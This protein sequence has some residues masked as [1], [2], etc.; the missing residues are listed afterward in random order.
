VDQL[1]QAKLKRHGGDAHAGLAAVATAE[2]RSV[3][4]SVADADVRQSLADLPTP[5]RPPLPSTVPYEPDARQRYTLTRLHATGGIGQVW[6]AHDEDLGRDVALKELRPDRRDNPAAAARFLEEAKITGQLEHPGIVPVYELVLPWEGQ[7]CYAMRFVGGRTLADAIREYHRKRQA[8]EAGPLDLRELLTAFVAV[9]NAVA[10]AHSRGVLHRDLKPANVALGDFG[11]VLL[12]DWGL[13]KVVGKAEEPTSL[14]PVAVGP[15]DG[16]GETRQGQVLGTPAYMPPEQARGR[17]DLVDRR[18]DVYGLGAI[19]YEV[20]T[21]EPPF[22]GADAQEVLKRVVQEP[23]LPPRRTVPTTP[24]ALQAVC[25]KAMAKEP[26]ARYET[27]RDLGRDVQHWLA[28]EPVAA[29]REPLRARAGRW[30]RRH[31]QLT[32]GLVVL[33]LTGLV[34]LGVGL[35]AVRAEQVRTAHERDL[36]EANL[37]LAKQAV[38][39]CFQLAKEHPLLQRD[40]MREVR[41]LLLEK[42]LPFYERFRAQRPDDPEIRAETA[43]NHYRVG[44]I[45]AELGR[46]ADAQQVYGQALRLLE[47]LAQE[48]PDVTQ[49]QDHLAW[50]YTNLGILQEQSGRRAEAERSYEEARRL[51]EHLV[52]GHPEV[53]AFQAVLAMIYV[54]LGHLQQ[55][56]GRRAEAERSYGEARRRYEL[57]AQEHPDIPEYQV[58]LAATYHNLGHLQQEWGRRAEAERSYGEARRLRE[59]LVREHPEVTQ[60]Q[61]H[62]AWTYTNLGNL[63]LQSGRRAE[64]ERSYE[65]ARRLGERLVR[66]HPEVTQYQDHLAGAY[67]NLGVFQ[68]GSGRRAEAERSCGEARR[69]YEQLAKQHPDVPEYQARL[70]EAYNNLGDLQRESGRRAEAERS[71]GEARRLREQ[72]AKQHPDVPGYRVALGGTYGALGRLQRDSGHARVALDWNAKAIE[73]FQAALAADPND[74]AARYWLRGANWDR[75]VALAYAGDYTQAVA[76]ANTL[77]QAKDVSADILYDMACV[78]S[79]SSAGV[80]NDAKL[81]DRYATRAVELLRQAVAKGWK[82]IDHLKKDTDL[83]PLRSRDDYKQL[84]K[85]ME[86]KP[87]PGK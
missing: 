61:D 30:A 58:G 22:S 67:T 70:A 57:L 42:A 15:A 20:L 77:A 54:N 41:K 14:L 32:T 7:A 83:D 79:L 17:V 80:K 5:A 28:D 47:Q 4:E 71:L 36:A 10:Y 34:G 23:V 84:M 43:E 12:L 29:Y 69:L 78:C 45:A 55:E 82:D 31:R 73:A 53:P 48:H 35:W 76:E 8:G 52:M 21:G 74:A 39:D 59:R 49:Y 27:A 38:D 50:T 44:Y 75:A 33:L 62:L 16:R 56:W 81:A 64:A 46:N 37:K 1:L 87:K 2:V 18:S 19:L 66:E 40:N 72:L 86:P 24:P 26:G 9:C 60:Y 6:L 63:Q 85:E 25:L 3:L 68:R 65:E 51:E 13:A 11:E